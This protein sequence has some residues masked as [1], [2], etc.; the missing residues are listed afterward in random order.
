MAFPSPLKAAAARLFRWLLKHGQE[1][2]DKELA[3]RGVPT[4]PVPPPP[5]FDFGKPDGPGS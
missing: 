1:E 2:L 3:K 4:A 5:S